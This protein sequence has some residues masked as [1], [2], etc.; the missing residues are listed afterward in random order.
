MSRAVGAGDPRRTTE[1]AVI[2]LGRKALALEE[3][4]YRDWL[5]QLTGRRS[6][7]D[8][9]SAQR[10]TVI[11]AMR[12]RGFSQSDR[13]MGAGLAKGMRGGSTLRPHQQKVRALWRALWNLGALHD[14]A[15]AALDRWIRGPQ[16]AGVDALRFADAK[17]CNMAIQGLRDWCRREGFETVSGEAGIDAKRGL[18]RAQ[19]RRLHA[20]GQVSIASTDALDAWLQSSGVARCKTAV[21][22][23]STDELDAAIERLGRWVR[24]VTV[25]KR[26]RCDDDGA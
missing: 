23:L 10:Q 12:A 7:A 26:G 25:H 9:S 22:L 14:G 2:H 19:W 11:E 17:A 15:D 8:L 4:A 24:K 21:D 1:L 3:D 18:L 6:A 13:G 20:C 16:G 5:Q